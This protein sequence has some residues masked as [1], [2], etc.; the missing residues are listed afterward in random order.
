MNGLANLQ[1][2]QQY[3]NQCAQVVEKWEAGNKITGPKFPPQPKTE[4]RCGALTTNGTPCK[5]KLLYANGYCK[6]H[7]GPKSGRVVL[8]GGNEHYIMIDGKAFIADVKHKESKP[9]AW[10]EDF[11]RQWML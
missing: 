1:A 4:S 8:K 5:G 9:V 7:G 6:Y 3:Y 2:L 11:F 10:D